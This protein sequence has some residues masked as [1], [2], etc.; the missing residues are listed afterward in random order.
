MLGPDNPLE[1]MRVADQCNAPGWT[2]G[3]WADYFESGSRDVIYNVISLEFSGTVLAD[4]VTR[5]TIVRQVDLVDRVWPSNISKPKVSLY[6]LMSVRGSYTD[7]HIDFGGS[8]VFYNVLRGAKTFILVPPKKRNL[9]AYKKWCKSPDQQRVFFGDLVSGCYQ[10]DLHEGDSFMIPSGWIHAVYTPADSLIIG[11]NFLTSLSF[12]KQVA[13]ANIEKQTQVPRKFRFPK[14]QRVLW[15]WVLYALNAPE[16]LSPDEL[17]GLSHV[18]Q[19]LLDASCQECDR[20]KKEYA[21]NI[22]REVEDAAAVLS[23]LEAFLDRNEVYH[24]TN[25]KKTERQNKRLK[26]EA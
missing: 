5:P 21:E 26:A 3:T 6:C 11:G 23:K 17:S 22:P 1:V 20:E 19:Y 8:S 24:T 25:S 15:Y 4:L 7:F 14:F 13:V 18:H 12:D 10:V 2:L 9:A 16:N